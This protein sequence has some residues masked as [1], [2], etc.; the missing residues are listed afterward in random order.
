M[1]TEA[2]AGISFVKNLMLGN[3]SNVSGD[4]VAYVDMHSTALA[5]VKAITVA[6]AANRRFILV[7]ESPTF[8]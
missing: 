5:H 3:M 6:E 1:R 4:G 8:H 7:K 2:T